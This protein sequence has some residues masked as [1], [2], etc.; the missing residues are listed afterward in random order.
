[1]TK[2]KT[3]TE[4]LSRP[5]LTVFLLSALLTACSSDDPKVTNPENGNGGNP[6]TEVPATGLFYKVIHVKN[7]QGSTSDANPTAPSATLYYSLEENKAVEGSYKKTRK[8]DLAFGGLYAS[9][10]S[11]NN[12]SNSQ[13]NG[14]L[15]GG[16]GGITIVAKPFNEVVDIPADNQFKTGIDLIGTDDAGSFG[17]GTGW[18]LYDFG[19]DVVS[20]GKNPQ[21]AHV[22]YALGESLKITNGTVIPA[23]TVILKTANGSYAKIKMISVYK[24]VYN[25]KDWYKDTPHMYYTFDYVMVPA[26]STKFE[27]K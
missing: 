26:G 20:D 23:R 4:K 17:N 19:G 21:K 7:Y 12:G 2:F 9:F 22:A 25:S 27:I 15:A 8:W 11:G 6:G 18:Y 14:S 16:I 24:D 13:N 10:L 1:M 3:L 5:L